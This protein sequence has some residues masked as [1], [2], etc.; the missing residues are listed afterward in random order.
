MLIA[1]SQLV[2]ILVNGGSGSVNRRITARLVV[3][4]VDDRGAVEDS[5]VILSIQLHEECLPLLD[6]LGSNVSKSR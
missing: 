4:S 3:S 6:Q 2:G 5:L 1:S